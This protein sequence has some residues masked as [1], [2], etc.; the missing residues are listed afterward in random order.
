MEDTI[1]IPAKPWTDA[2][3]AFLTR[4]A[5]FLPQ[6]VQD[7]LGLTPAVPNNNFQ[8]DFDAAREIESPVVETGEIEPSG[9]TETE[10]PTPEEITKGIEAFNALPPEDQEAARVAA[11]AEVVNNE[12]TDNA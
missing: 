10:M 12:A 7:E 5:A 4:N 1:T 9:V 2:D 3:V 11:Q 8:A 6:E